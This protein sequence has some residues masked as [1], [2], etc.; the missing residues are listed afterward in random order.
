[1]LDLFRWD[2]RIASGVRRLSTRT[3]RAPDASCN[4]WSARGVRA[5]VRSRP[6]AVCHD[7]PQQGVRIGSNVGADWSSCFGTSLV[8]AT[9][10]V[11][12]PARASTPEIQRFCASVE[13][14]GKSTP[15]PDPCPDRFYSTSTAMPR[16]C[17]VLDQHG[18]ELATRAHSRVAHK[19]TL[20]FVNQSDTMCRLATWFDVLRLG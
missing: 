8:A 1:M 5:S 3:L 20:A 14:R 19:I 15:C 4:T 17:V 12:E 9:C 11:A 6:L 2:E 10:S 18:G 16:D 13:L 7:W